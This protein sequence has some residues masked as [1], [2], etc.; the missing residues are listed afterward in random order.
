[1]GAMPLSAERQSGTPVQVRRPVPGCGIVL[2][3]AYNEA[4]TVGRLVH[5]LRERHGLDVVVIDDMSD[6]GTAARAEA[7]GATVLR[8]CSRLGA[9]GAA[10]AG[11]RYAIVRGYAFALTMDA[12]GQHSAGDVPR[13]LG[14]LH[15]GEAD[16]VIGACVARG[17]ALR[18]WA[19]RYLRLLTGFEVTDMTSG[20]RAYNLQAL[21]TLATS[22]ATLLDYQDVG[23]LFLLHRAGARIVEVGVSMNERLVGHSRLFH[24]WLRVAKYMLETT[25]LCIAK[26]GRGRRVEKG[27]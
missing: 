2:M 1:M 24:T 17:S 23:V 14:P 10:Q 18:R 16:V 6:D 5:Q 25:M 9:W 12:D 15:A 22:E 4:S 27:P 20:F 8:L 21:R 3:P 13:M 7:A 26:V 11:M 19:W